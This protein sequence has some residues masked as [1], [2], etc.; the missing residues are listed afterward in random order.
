MPSDL[1]AVER[2]AAHLQLTGNT[3]LDN[4][5]AQIA[6]INGSLEVIDSTELANRWCLPESWIREQT[7]SR[8]VDPIPH[9]RLGRYVRFEWNSPV[10]LQWWNRHRASDVKPASKFN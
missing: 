1:S 3:Q 6:H 10:L 7:R 4:P 8:A 2:T 9:V 5:R